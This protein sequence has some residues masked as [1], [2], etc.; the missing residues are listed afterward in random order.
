MALSA[1][2]GSFLSP[3]HFGRGVGERLAET[4]YSLS[5]LLNLAI[6]IQYYR[7]STLLSLTAM[8]LGGEF[9]LLHD[10]EGPDL[11]YSLQKEVW[12]LKF[13]HVSTLLTRE[14]N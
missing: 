1:T 10:L 4:K 6:D 9:F 12:R 2:V 14:A 8:L 11:S 13:R 5:S 7:N 3:S